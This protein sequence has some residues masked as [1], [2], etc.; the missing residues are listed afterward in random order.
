M[1]YGDKKWLF[2]GGLINFKI[3]IKK[4]IRVSYFLAE[5]EKWNCHGN[6]RSSFFG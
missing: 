3:I 6:K 4:N 1:L 5:I 2:R